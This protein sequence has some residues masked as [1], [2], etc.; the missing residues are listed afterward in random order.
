MSRPGRNGA[1]GDKWSAGAANGSRRYASESL[2]L[3]E[4]VDFAK[5]V[6]ARFLE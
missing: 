1:G 2:L 4:F 5:E 3:Q 6:E